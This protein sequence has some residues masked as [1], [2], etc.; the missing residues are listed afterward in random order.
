MSGLAGSESMLPLQR[1]VAGRIAVNSTEQRLIDL[2]T[3]L[4][5]W[6]SPGGRATKANLSL[7]LK[8]HAL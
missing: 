1:G 8:P 6:T 2:T 7:A 4:Y 3:T 5:G